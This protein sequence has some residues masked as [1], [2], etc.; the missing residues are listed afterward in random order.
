V[1]EG[2]MLVLEA[3]K[4]ITHF[5]LQRVEAKRSYQLPVES[6]GDLTTMSLPKEWEAVEAS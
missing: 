1:L 5:T 6:P 2:C 3:D 4:T